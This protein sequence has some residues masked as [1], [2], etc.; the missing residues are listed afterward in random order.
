MN[1]LR[2]SVSPA[3]HRKMM[4]RALGTLDLSESESKTDPFFANS[5]EV[6]YPSED[7][8]RYNYNSVTEKWEMSSV[9]IRIAEKHFAEGGMRLAYRSGIINPEATVTSC[10]VKV[11]KH[12]DAVTPDMVFHEALTQSVAQSYA[13]AFNALAEEKGLRKKTK[14]KFLPVTV[15]HLP[16]RGPNYY[17]AAEPYLKYSSTYV[18]HNDNRGG[19]ARETAEG[20]LAQAFSYFTFVASKGALVVCD[21]QGVGNTFTDP[22]IHSAD[23]KRLFG[24]GNM[25]QKGIDTFLATFEYNEMCAVMGLPKPAPHADYVEMRQIMNELGSFTNFRTSVMNHA[26]VQKQAALRYSKL[27]AEEQEQRR[28]SEERKAR[29]P[30]PKGEGG[31]ARR[32]LSRLVRRLTGTGGGS[33]LSS[34]PNPIKKRLSQPVSRAP[35]LPPRKNASDSNKSSKSDEDSFKVRSRPRE[36]TLEELADLM[37]GNDGRFVQDSTNEYNLFH[38][39]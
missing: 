19:A 20:E 38:L 6:F 33:K 28:L 5:G 9:R 11:F 26:T 37:P 12:V 1:H 24:A 30:A 29:S 31:G 17:A 7:A 16:Q 25:G 39:V 36:R 21:I 35:P 8:T 3:E 27:K 13:V 14:V 22:Q 4:E 10:V 2:M 18:K 15:L 34:S 23:G 32:S